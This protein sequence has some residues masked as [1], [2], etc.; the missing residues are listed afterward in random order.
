[1]ICVSMQHVLVNLFMLLLFLSYSFCYWTD[2]GH[3]YNVIFT[4]I[5]FL[6]STVMI[7]FWLINRVDNKKRG[8]HEV[9]ELTTNI[10]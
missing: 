9:C 5:T 4:A 3:W 6:Y 7:H 2:L 8:K 10:N 1:M